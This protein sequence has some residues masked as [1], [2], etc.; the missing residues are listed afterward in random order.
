MKVELSSIHK[1]FGPVR[2]NDGITLTIEGGTIFGLLGENGAGKSTLM[3]VLSGFITA[4]RGEIRLND[5][6]AEFSTPSEAIAHGVGMLHQDPLDFPP[7]SLLDNFITGRDS[8][9]W[10]GRTEARRRFLEL[11]RQFD[12]DLDP[13]MAVREISVGERQ[14]LEIVRLLWLGVQTLIL[15]EPTT[16]ISAPQKIKL[17]ATLKQLAA[18]GKSII[19][20]S[21]KL[22]DVEALCDRAGVLR[23]GKLMGVKP[24]PFVADELVELMF[25]QLIT[26]ERRPDV[27]LGQPLLALQAVT[28]TDYTLPME[29]VNLEI[30]AGEVIGLAGLEGSGQRLF[31]QGCAGLIPVKEGSLKL[32]G[33]DMAGA[34]YR[35]YLDAGV[36]FMPA[37]RMA[38]GLIPGLSIAEHMVLAQH[39]RGQ[40]RTRTIDWGSAVRTSQAE[41]GEF[42]IKGRP[43]STVESL[44][45]GNQQRTLLA[46]LP[47]KLRLL[48]MEH[49]TRGLDV[50]SAIYI[51][52]KLLARRKSGTAIIFA[53]A[54]LDEV[55]QYSDRILVC[56]GGQIT[57]VVRTAETSVSEL[58]FLIAGREKEAS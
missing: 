50:E 45:G 31:M 58:G 44:S 4:D 47:D 24:A 33:Q 54:D 55:F 5:Q 10:Q 21:H 35:R 9:L 46:L 13:D 18:E 16:G 8:K 26:L 23:Q 12:F 22:E 57:G 7:M 28:F 32:D 3:K 43:D 6:P 11:C 34:P 51:W 56:Y 14:Q 36:A 52:N 53:S 29:D 30:Q 15:D 2:A 1:H 42:N 38:E 17:F 20:V 19:F 48:I 49:P 25:G 41:I 27:P 40:H 37:D 39:R